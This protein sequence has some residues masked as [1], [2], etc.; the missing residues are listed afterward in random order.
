[1][2]GAD[3]TRTAPAMARPREMRTA[4]LRAGELYAGARRDLERGAWREAAAALAQAGQWLAAG[5]GTSAVGDEEL[6]AAAATAR[7]ALAALRR[8]VGE[9]LETVAADRA[10]VRE[11]RNTLRRFTPRSGGTTAG[12]WLD[13]SG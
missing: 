7:E 10:Q 2:T 13:Q 12:R 8:T 1:M 3:R 6:R 9:Q 4:I 11:R 5:E